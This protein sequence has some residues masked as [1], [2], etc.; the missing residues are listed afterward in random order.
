[1]I[2]IISDELNII[3]KSDK[4]VLLLLGGWNFSFCSLSKSVC[5]MLKELNIHFSSVSLLNYPNV[6]EFIQT[7]HP[8]MLAPYLFVDG[9]FIGGFDEISAL[10][11]TNQLKTIIHSKIKYASTKNLGLKV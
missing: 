6:K 4:V 2:D 9:Y 10:Y 5:C 3:I 7:K 1:M 11:Y 8:E